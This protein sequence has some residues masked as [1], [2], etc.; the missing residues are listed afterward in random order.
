MYHV[1]LAGPISGLTFDQAQ[2]WRDIA[3]AKLERSGRIKTLSPLRGKEYLRDHG[4]LE[5]SYNES[6]LSTDQGLTARDRFDCTRSDVVI[7]NMHGCG[8]R[9]SIGTCFE[10]AWHDLT[11]NIGILVMEPEGNVHDYPMV[12]ETCKFRVDSLGDALKLTEAILLG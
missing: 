12:R 4:K 7:F 5:G 2:S 6:P 10:F 1:Y 8:P 9:V 3:K 11:R